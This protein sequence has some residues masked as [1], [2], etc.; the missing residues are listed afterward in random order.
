[1]ANHFQKTD[2]TLCYHVSLFCHLPTR[3][4]FTFVSLFEKPNS[5]FFGQPNS[6]QTL[7]SNNSPRADWINIPAVASSRCVW[8][9]HQSDLSWFQ[10]L[11]GGSVF[12]IGS[13]SR[14]YLVCLSADEYECHSV[15]THWRRLFRADWLVARFEIIHL[16]VFLKKNYL[17]DSV[18][19]PWCQTGS[20]KIQHIL[21]RTKQS[22]KSPKVRR[23]MSAK[24]HQQV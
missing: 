12:V 23:M 1:M 22:E 20:F 14:L 7:K 16:A 8:C 10:L 13:L 2:T 6:R 18:R 9:Q 11:H 24:P 4:F 17:S 15:Q 3:H 19:E 5:R 21:A